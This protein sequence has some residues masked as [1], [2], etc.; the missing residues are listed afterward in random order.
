MYFISEIKT[1]IIIIIKVLKHTHIKQ[2]KAL[3]INQSSYEN[4]PPKKF[5][6]LAKPLT[7]NVKHH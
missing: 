3:S 6:T 7:A 2:A 1:I 4:F 5:E